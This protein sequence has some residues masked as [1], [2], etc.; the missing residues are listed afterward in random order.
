MMH[1]RRKFRDITEFS[2]I[3][4]TPLFFSCNGYNINVLMLY[5]FILTH[6]KI[7]TSLIVETL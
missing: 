3:F 7:D 6:D 1:A 2:N 5:N 4:K